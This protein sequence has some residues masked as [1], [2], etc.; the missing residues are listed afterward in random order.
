MPAL[1]LTPTEPKQQLLNCPKPPTVNTSTQSLVSSSFP[2]SSHG[3]SAAMGC[4]QGSSASQVEV[5]IS[6]PY[7]TLNPISPQTPNTL[8]PKP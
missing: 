3:S 2:P 7:S 4:C 6:I 8:N 5:Q 1:N